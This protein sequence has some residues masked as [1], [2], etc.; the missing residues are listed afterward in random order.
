MFRRSALIVVLGAAL[1]ACAGAAGHAHPQTRIAGRIRVVTVSV[2]FLL[3]R[4][5][6]VPPIR[7]PSKIAMIVSAVNHLPPLRPGA[8]SCPV[9]RGPNVMLR[10]FD[11]VGSPP[12]ATAD[13][14]GSG[15]GVVGIAVRGQRHAAAQG[16]PGL[17][18]RLIRL[19]VL[20]RSVGRRD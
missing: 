7:A 9:D 13:A 8:Y 4:R 11:A 5:L 19:G 16:G 17:I 14:D 2:R 18:A 20:P 15:C 12:L 10:F 1:A 6:D 3:G